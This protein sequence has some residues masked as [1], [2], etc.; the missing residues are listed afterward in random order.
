MAYSDSMLTV[1][2]FIRYA[3]EDTV[4]RYLETLFELQEDLI[5]DGARNFLF[6]DVPPVHRSPSGTQHPPCPYALMCN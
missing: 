3:T 5:E 1:D 6:I 4:P 2:V